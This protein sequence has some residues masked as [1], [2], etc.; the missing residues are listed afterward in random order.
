MIEEP[1]FARLFCF[2]ST[3]V[4]ANCRSGKLHISGYTSGMNYDDAYAKAMDEL[5]ASPILEGNYAPPMHQLLRRLGYHPLP[6]H[7][8]NFGLNWLM[9]GVPFGIIWGALMWLIS[10]DVQEL[11]PIVAL[12]ASAL[13]GALFGFALA[14]YYRWSAKRHGLSAWDDLSR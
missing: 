1:G 12:W 7:Y 11:S 3:T 13:A 6:P 10:W 4:M 14:V 5:E 9:T 8:A 2:A